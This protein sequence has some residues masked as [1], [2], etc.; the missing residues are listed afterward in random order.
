LKKPEI[1]NILIVFILGM[2]NPMTNQVSPT[3]IVVQT[4]S[5]VKQQYSIPDAYKGKKS[6]K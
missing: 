5:P 6:R 4:Q 2:Q 3:V 1:I